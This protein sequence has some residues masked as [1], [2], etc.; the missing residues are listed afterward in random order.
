MHLKL[1]V[2]LGKLN[3]YL[4]N[5]F[6]WIIGILRGFDARSVLS[7]LATNLMTRGYGA[8]GMGSQVVSLNLTNLLILVLLKGLI[9]AAASLAGHKG[10]GGRYNQT[11]Y[12][13]QK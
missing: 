3:I 1:I 12:L 5:I 9:F 13:H 2:W 10:E 8:T 4:K 6:M 7:S 11:H